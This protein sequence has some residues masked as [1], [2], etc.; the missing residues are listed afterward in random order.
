MPTALSDLR[1]TS[2]RLQG[3]KLVVVPGAEALDE[4]A[5]RA[6]LDA[7]RAG[8][9]VLFTGAIEGDSYGRETSSLRALGVLGAS[10][11]VAMHEKS[12]WSSSGWVAFD[13]LLQESLRRADRPSVAT[14]S[15]AVWVEPLPIELARERE[16]LVKLLD[17]ALSA[18]GIPSSPGE[19]GVAARALV[20]P[21][22]TLITVV[23]ERP[24]R[25]VR[26]VNAG[27]SALDIPVAALGAR[28]VLVE[29]ATGRIVAATPGDP[30][31]AA[32]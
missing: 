15:G 30:I 14:L 16:P 5:A 27:R 9:K 1:L 31:V 21:K 25:A 26:R 24:E 32:H 28:L 4:T 2:A 22:A 29:R 11:P 12:A 3:V 20:A 8:T 17:A 10:R 6:L 18:A 23:N 19:W 13:G 7:S